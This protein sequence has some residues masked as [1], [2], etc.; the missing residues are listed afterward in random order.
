MTET[1][2]LADKALFLHA[3]IVED[4][5]Q[6]RVAEMNR[7]RL[8][9]TPA[10]QPDEDG[11]CRGTG[12][13]PPGIQPG[14][15]VA[16][17]VM[18][19]ARKHLREAGQKDGRVIPP[20]DWHAAVWSLCMILLQLRATEEAAVTELEKAMRRHPLGEF[21]KSVTGLGAKQFGRLLGI[22]GDPYVRGVQAGPDGA[23]LPPAPRT[24]SQLR[25][26]C[27]HGDPA[28][29]PFKGM[30]QEDARALGRPDA[31]MRL[32][33]IAE[34]FIRYT[35]EPDKNGKPTPLSPYRIV[36]DD[37]RKEYAERVHEG[38][39]LNRSRISPNGCGTRDHPEW[40]APGSPWRDGHQ[41]GAAIRL[42][43]KRFLDDLY[44]EAK[45]LHEERDASD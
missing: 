5:E 45:R 35:G 41:H 38:E 37:A 33:L 30:T 19:A 29:K 12:W 9:V 21:E 4:L 39:C 23:E 34:Q 26:L 2:W 27:G 36:Y 44:D 7:L 43:A 40:G 17:K 28:R 8:L 25:S 24:R 1:P 18:D 15:Q 10:D 3:A 16:A 13:L 42:V 14:K 32:H 22:I 11:M 31:K 6:V 20:K